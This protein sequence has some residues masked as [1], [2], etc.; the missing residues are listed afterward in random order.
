M[1]SEDIKHQLIIIPWT[2]QTC[3]AEWQTFTGTYVLHSRELCYIPHKRSLLCRLGFSPSPQSAQSSESTS[4]SLKVD[5]PDPQSQLL[6]PPAL[7]Y[8]GLALSSESVQSSELTIPAPTVA[9]W[10]NPYSQLVQ[11]SGSTSPTLKVY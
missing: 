11:P 6:S 8:I 7:K 3:T 4:P 10:H 1:T 5:W 9:D 2:D